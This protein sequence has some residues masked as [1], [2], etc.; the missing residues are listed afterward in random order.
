MPTPTDQSTLDDWVEWLLHLHTTEIDLGLDRISTVAERMKLERPAHFVIS[1]AGTNGKGSSV[2]MLAS[3]LD[4]A[5]YKVGCYTSPHIVCFT[6]RIQ[7]NGKP[8]SPQTVVDAFVEIE[9]QR[10][11]TKLTYFE[12]STLAALKIFK[13]A[14]LDV[15]VLEVG[16]GGRLD[17]VNV[18]DA[19]AALITAID[20]DHIEWLGDDRNQ[21]AVEKAGIMRPG[22][23]AVCSDPDVPQ[24]LIKHADQLQAKLALLTRDYYYEVAPDGQRW[25]YAA[26]GKVIDLVPPALQGGFQFQNAAGVVC[27]LQMSRPHLAILPEQINLGLKQARHPGR[28]ES[29]EYQH[30]NW[31]IDVAH[32]PQS[33]RVLAQYLQSQSTAIQPRVAVFAALSDK[34]MKPMIQSL[35]PFITTWYIGH[36][37]NPRA[38]SVEALHQILVDSGVQPNQIHAC[39]TIAEAVEQVTALPQRAVL[40]WGSFFTVAEVLKVLD[41][42]KGENVGSGQ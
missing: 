8:V 30:Q 27:L 7:I 22:K 31:L 34:D 37:H 3:I 12:F 14:A 5:G 16:L 20:I 41:D 21:I 15:V 1:V 42:Q 4:A 33:A 35:A 19:D 39:P 23:V 13:E 25:R 2:A 24:T 38:C 36:L 18:I 10:Q 32:N 26:D 11:T 6:E 9:A 28:L 40:A 17:A 29:R